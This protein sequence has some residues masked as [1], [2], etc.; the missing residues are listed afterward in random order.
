MR[1]TPFLS[2]YGVRHGIQAVHI[3]PEDVR[4]L[5]QG[6]LI[7]EDVLNEYVVEISYDPSKEPRGRQVVDLD[8]EFFSKGGWQI[9]Q[10]S[11][12]LT[13]VAEVAALAGV[14]IDRL[15]ERV[16]AAG[17]G[18]SGQHPEAGWPDGGIV[19]ADVPAI[20]ALFSADPGDDER[21]AGEDLPVQ[22]DGATSAATPGAE[23]DDSSQSGGAGT[24]MTRGTIIGTDRISEIQQ[25]VADL[26]SVRPADHD[27]FYYQNGFWELHLAVRDLLQEVAPG[28]ED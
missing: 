15:R 28:Y 1:D 24:A 26:D 19:T 7:E 10:P 11:E 14:A 8:E 22:E 12:F 21:T 3:G 20:L 25:L 27:A 23:S 5:L 13:P 6:G 4:R 9:N 2:P 18:L 17:L 16:R